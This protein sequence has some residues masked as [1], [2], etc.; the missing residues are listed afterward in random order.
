MA[1][2]TAIV[3]H[4]WYDRKEFDDFDATSSNE[5]EEHVFNK[6]QTQSEEV[7]LA[8]PA[9]RPLRA[10]AGLFRSDESNNGGFLSDFT[11]VSSLRDIFD[12]SYDQSAEISMLTVS[13]I[14]S[15]RMLLRVERGKGG[16][17]QRHALGRPA[18]P[19]A[20]LVAG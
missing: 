5:G 13:D 14:D 6:I 15:E 19:A 18:R 9:N 3:A 16:Q 20:R 4:E 17:Y 2:L 12:S 7:R 11:D 1:E 10:L 8:T